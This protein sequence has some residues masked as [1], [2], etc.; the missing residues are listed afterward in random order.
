MG[1]RKTESLPIVGVNSVSKGLEAEPL[2][3]SLSGVRGSGGEMG[4]QKS[5][6]PSLTEP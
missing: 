6:E 1:K 3:A 4:L 5:L 2:L